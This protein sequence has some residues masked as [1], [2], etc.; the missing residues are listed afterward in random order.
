LQNTNW[1]AFEQLVKSAMERENIPGM[2]VAVARDGEMIYAAGFGDKDRSTGAP[3]DKDTLFG[4]ASVSKSFT[5][6]AIMQLVDAGK[7]S[8]DDP[9]VKHVPEFSLGG[10][11]ETGDIKIHHLLSHTSG[12]APL[13]GLRYAWAST[14]SGYPKWDDSEAEA[15]L[16]ALYGKA[17]DLSTFPK[18]ISWLSHEPVDMLGKPGEYFSYSNDGYAI[19]G[20]VIEHVTSRDYYDYMAKN[21]F[22]AI[23][24]PRTTLH[25]SD[26]AGMGNVTKLYFHNKKH[27]VKDVPQWQDIKVYDAGGGVRSTVVDLAMYGQVYASDGIAGKKRIISPRSAQLMRTPAYNIA[28]GTYYCYG[29]QITPGYAG[30]TLVEHGGSLTGVGAAFGF[31]PEKGLS[32]A[33][34]A[35][36]TRVASPEVW[37]AAV[38]TAMGLPLNQKRTVEIPAKKVSPE[39]IKRFSGQYQ[40]G[41]F[42]NFRIHADGDALFIMMN[43]LTHEL[44]AR[45]EDTLIYHGAFRDDAVKFYSRP[46]GEVWAAFQGLR[47]V[48]KVS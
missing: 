1:T 43:G 48:R 32:C 15:P 46:S 44:Y 41:E 6:M 17:P 14:M 10:R 23:G 18:Y 21:V 42:G 34:I 22:Q 7:L 40:S 31:V 38:N 20:S 29:L 9:V 26:L 37:L 13:P 4:I 39:Q 3:V 2:A 8:V 28:P 12:I 45:D 47:M 27:E 11:K 19:L 24:L 30:C 33:V 25:L 35:N 5:A 36:T 16:D